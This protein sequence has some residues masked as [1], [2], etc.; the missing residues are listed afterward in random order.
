MYTHMSRH[1]GVQA[2]PLSL[3]IT[4]SHTHSIWEEVLIFLRLRKQNV[5]AFYNLMHTV[6][7]IEKR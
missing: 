2:Q 5:P 4:L 1:V 7:Q 6:L 3:S